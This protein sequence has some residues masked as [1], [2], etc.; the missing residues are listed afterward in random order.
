MPKSL[1]QFKSEKT[2]TS[3]FTAGFLGT[4]ILRKESIY[5]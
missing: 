5:Q 3:I 4:S 1:T 2:I